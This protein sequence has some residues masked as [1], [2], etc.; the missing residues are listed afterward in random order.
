MAMHKHS[1]FLECIKT[2][3]HKNYQY[4]FFSYLLWLYFLY[5]I[6]HLEETKRMQKEY[7]IFILCAFICD[8]RE[9]M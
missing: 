5:N 6:K 4:M 7:L 9:I 2:E 1:P 8:L 3:M